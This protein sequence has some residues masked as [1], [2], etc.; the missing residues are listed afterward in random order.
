MVGRERERTD[1]A[2]ALADARGGRG[3]AVLLLGEAGK[4]KSMLA[5]WTAGRAA[6]DGISAGWGWWPEP[7][8]TWEVSW[9][10]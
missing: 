7:G 10:A 8:I 5:E 9:P 6:A 3:R 2:A 4:G 1:L